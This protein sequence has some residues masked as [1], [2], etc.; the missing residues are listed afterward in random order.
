[1]M[2]QVY[3]QPVETHHLKAETHQKLTQTHQPV[4][5]VINQPKAGPNK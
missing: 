4:E 1:M 2:Y 5:M 3:H